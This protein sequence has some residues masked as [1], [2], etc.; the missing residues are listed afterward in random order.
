[1]RGENG[2]YLVSEANSMVLTLIFGHLFSFTD[3]E[4]EAQKRLKALSKVTWQPSWQEM[5]VFLTPESGSFL[6]DLLN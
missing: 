2:G 3:K 6:T 1:M 4:T 5:F